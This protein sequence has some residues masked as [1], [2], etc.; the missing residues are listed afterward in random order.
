MQ[1]PMPTNVKQLQGFLGLVNFYR[2]FLPGIVGTLRPL[3]DSLLGNPK[4]LDV[5]PAMT[6]AVT[7]AKTALAAATVLAHPAPDAT[8]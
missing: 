2:R 3:T 8:L 1:L 6:A 5:T 7:A 4:V